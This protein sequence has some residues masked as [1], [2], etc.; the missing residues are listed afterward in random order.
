MLMLY[1]ILFFSNDQEHPEANQIEAINKVG[2]IEAVNNSKLDLFDKYLVN[3]PVRQI[4]CSGP[5]GH[6]VA[7]TADPALS[8]GV[9]WGF[10]HFALLVGPFRGWE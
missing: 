4:L 1:R 10:S 6:T 9:H 8:L 3:T 7:N 2:F 5:R